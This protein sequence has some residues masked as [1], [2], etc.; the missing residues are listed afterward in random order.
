MRVVRVAVPCGS[1]AFILSSPVYTPSVIVGN[2]AASALKPGFGCVCCRPLPAESCRLGP[3]PFGSTLLPRLSVRLTALGA[4][5]ESAVHRHCQSRRY[6]LADGLCTDRGRGIFRPRKLPAAE[7]HGCGNFG[8]RQL[9]AAH[10]RLS[11]CS[12]QARLMPRATRIGKA[13]ES[14]VACR[15][16][17]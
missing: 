6:P 7:T 16:P 14:G 12:L 1:G 8:L 15:P 5:S 10:T 9:P 2:P 17:A 3:A 4:P 11:A 13:A